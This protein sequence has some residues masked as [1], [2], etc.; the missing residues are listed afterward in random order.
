MVRRLGFTN[1]LKRGVVFL[2]RMTSQDLDRQSRE[3]ALNVLLLGTLVL[4]V[5]ALAVVLSNF[6]FLGFHY[7]WPRIGAI[8]LLL[9]GMAVLY[10]MFRRGHYALPTYSLLALYF[11]AAC[12]V[13]FQWGVNN[14]VGLLLLAFVTILSGILIGARYSLYTVLLAVA[15]LTILSWLALQGFIHPDM[16]WARHLAGIYDVVVFGII[17]AN[18][19]VISWLFN[20]SMEQSL[21]RAQKS[22]K[23][24]RRQKQLLEVKVEERTR[25]VQAAHLERVQELYR[26]AEL[27]HMSVAL[28][29]D[30]ANYLTVLSLD[31]ED[32]RQTRRNRTE[33]MS[34]VQQ[35]IRHLNSLVGRVRHQIKG[36]T[37]VVQFNIADEIDQV[38]KILEYKANAAHVSLVWQS[39]P[40]RDDLYYTGSIN[41]FWQVITNIISNG[42]DAYDT[43]HDL[44]RSIYVVAE[45]TKA[46][47][48]VRVIDFGKGIPETKYE[49]VFEP[50]YS[51]KKT[52]TGIGLAIAKRM[53]EKDFSGTIQV[54]SSKERGTIFTIVLPYHAEAPNH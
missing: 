26:F 52:G 37:S 3:L 53:V 25:Q 16:T 23:A 35:S 17:L 46:G 42:I 7:L 33:A 32:L 30:M 2:F 11:V 24:L 21:A 4:I 40:K 22:E 36:E 1:A 49:K 43:K 20:R 18:V 27:G 31:I 15:T 54:E 29:H 34:R 14:P 39:L 19:A 9:V 47:I 12:T 48:T 51:T 6:I 28:L 38:M 8:I 45:K 50:F 13:L 5:G 44:T 41:H 10:K